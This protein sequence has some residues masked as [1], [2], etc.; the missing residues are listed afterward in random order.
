MKRL[1][2]IVAGGILAASL[3]AQAQTPVYSVNAVGYTKVA[4]PAGAT[5]LAIPFSQ[6]GGGA[7]SIDAAFGTQVPD[8]ATLFFYV[9]GSG[10]V[11]YQYFYPDGWYDGNFN[12]AGS[13][14]IVRGEGFWFVSQT[15]TNI[16]IAGEVPGQADATNSITIVPGA[17]LVSFA[18]PAA[19]S[20]TNGTFTPADQDTIFSYT[21]GSGYQSYQYFAPDGWYDSNFNLV[22]VD[23]AVGQGYWYI[24]YA[25]GTTVWKQAKPYNWP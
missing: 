25:S 12:L 13:N 2:A 5:L 11:S 14:K 24:S 20:V 4:I 8:Q 15:A 22:N 21:P 1:S 9:P 17:Q 3:V 18:Y 7:L 10:Y 19:G 16:T 6:V 23:L